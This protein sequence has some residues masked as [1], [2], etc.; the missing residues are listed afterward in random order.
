MAYT[1]FYCQNGGSNLNSGSTTNNT[2][3][4]TSAGGN[5]VQSTRVFTPTDG[6]NPVTAGVTTGMFAS[7]YVTAGATATGYIGRISAVTNATNGTITIDGSINYGSAPA[8]GTGTITLKVGGALAGPSGSTTFPLGLTGTL[9]TLVNT[10]S[11]PFRLNA[12]NDQTYAMTSAL[13]FNVLSGGG[14]IQGYSSSVGDGGKA[15]FTSTVTG[16]AP[17]SIGSGSALN[18]VDI[19]FSFVGSA[20]G[21]QPLFNV[22]AAGSVMFLRVVFH[23]ARGAGLASAASINIYVIESEAYACNASA[24]SSLGG[25]CKTSGS[26][27]FVFINTF[28]HDH[29]G[30]NGHGFVNS[31]SGS[32][33]VL[34]NSIAANCGGKGAFIPAGGT[35]NSLIS[36][37]SNY[38][39]NTGDA[40]TIGSVNPWVLD[41]L[42]NNNFVKNNGK[43]I[44]C[45]ATKQAGIIYNNG[46]G[47]GTQANGSADALGSIIDSGTDITYASDVTPWNA[48]TTGDF[49]TT[50][51]AAQGAG[52]GHFEENDGTHTGTVGYPDIGAAQHRDTQKAYTFTG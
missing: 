50:L 47:S 52:R 5:W 41:L 31:T 23:G 28:S 35:Q 48:P 2:A 1:E 36:I 6:V 46:R 42:M 25:F 15:S 13:A 17:F 40:I 29:S 20:S 10:N 11:D 22:A 21:S 18:I 37:N 51:A 27:A 38:Y 44:N 26:G 39:N 14:T 49:R 32:E 3:A 12:K 7:V 24:T 8:N 43:A 4:Y 9:S 34:I 19:N 16:S 30:S 45:S 33:M